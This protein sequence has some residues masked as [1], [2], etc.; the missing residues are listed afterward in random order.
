M[1]E[2]LS[3]LLDNGLNRTGAFSEGASSGSCSVRE[4][5]RPCRHPATATMMWS[6]DVKKVV[7]EC[8]LK[9]KPVNEDG[10]PIRGYRQRMFRVWQEIGLFEATEQRPCD[11][12]RAIRKNGWLSELDTDVIKRKISKEDA[13]DINV[14][15]QT[16]GDSTTN[17]NVEDEEIQLEAGEFDTQDEYGGHANIKE[18][19][20]ISEE[21][22]RIITE[23]LELSKSGGNNPVNLKKANR[24][25]LEEITYRSIRS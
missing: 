6:K 4:Q 8:Y 5:R 23:I 12:L 1:G 9:S 7:M 11:Q 13:G 17:E 25:Q 3:G 21:D 22:R 20:D 16:L 24:R 15:D 10:V 19:N 14:Q 18:L 2:S